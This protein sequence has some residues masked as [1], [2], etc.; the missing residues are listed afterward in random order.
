[1]SKQTYLYSLSPDE[2]ASYETG[3]KNLMWLVKLLGF[4]IAGLT[5]LL[6]YYV[7]EVVPQDRFYASM[8]QGQR[9]RMVA[10]DDPNI[11]DQTLLD[12]AE[13]AAVEILTFGFHDIDER[14]AISRKNFTDAGWQ[15]FGVAMGKSALLKNIMEN[16]QILTAIPR[17][18]AKLVS[19]GLLNGK[20]TWVIQIQLIVTTRAGGQIS[21]SRMPLLIRVVRLPTEQNPRGI[22][23]ETWLAGG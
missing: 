17:E 22:G 3:F 12:W 7:V 15:S 9:L 18:P 16:R 23:I 20:F 14:F 2:S 5:G 19:S 4:V 13:Q 10:L 11:N 21:N 1:M 8:A 6:L